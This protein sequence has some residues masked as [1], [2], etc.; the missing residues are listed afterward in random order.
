MANCCLLSRLSLPWVQA[1]SRRDFPASLKGRP[2]HRSL[3]ACRRHEHTRQLPPHGRADPAPCSFPPAVLRREVPSFVSRACD[4]S[5]RACPLPISTHRGYR[6]RGSGRS[7]SLAR[8]RRRSGH[9][10]GDLSRERI[11]R[12][13][14]PRRPHQRVRA[15]YHGEVEAGSGVPGR[16][17]SSANTPTAWAAPIRRAADQC[18]PVRRVA[19]FAKRPAPWAERAMVVNP[20]D[21]ADSTPVRPPRTGGLRGQAHQ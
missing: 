10:S 3:R 6:C 20:I 7:P 9:G 4:G 8:R 14:G 16:A 13:A 21:N 19:T 12:W 1:C 18:V 17:S 15:R 2:P 5:D 11:R